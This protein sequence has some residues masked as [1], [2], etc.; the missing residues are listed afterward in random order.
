MH[1]MSL[2]KPHERRIG[3]T[4]QTYSAIL[5]ARNTAG[6]MT[7]KDLTGLTVTFSMVNAATGAVKVSAQS[8]TIVTAASGIVSYD[9][10]A[11]DVDTA[12]IYWGRFTVTQSGETNTYPAD[13]RDGIIWIHGHA[14]TAQQAY[15]AALP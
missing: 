8:A 7:A 2:N 14:Q 11:G 10:A 3:D 6:V 4:T 1:T 9:F 13:P 5:Q 12:G 15:E